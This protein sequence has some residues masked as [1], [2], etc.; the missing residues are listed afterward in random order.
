LNHPQ[1]VPYG[2]YVDIINTIGKWKVIDLKSLT[3]FCNFGISY[4][5]LAIKVMTLEKEGFVKSV[6]L[7]RKRKHLFL[8]DKGIRLTGH[9]N[10]YE[11]TDASLG[12]DILVGT[13]LR[14]LLKSESFY[15]G[16]MFHE[17]D[18]SEIYPDAVVS[19]TKGKRNYELAIEIELTQKSDPR[20]K[21]KYSRYSRSK[22]FDYCIF[23]TNKEA[24]FKAYKRFL[25]EMTKDVQT[26]VILMLA[27][28]LRPDR[29]EY[30]GEKCF[31][32]GEHK[33]FEE[34]FCD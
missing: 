26:K 6:N 13:A 2:A 7:K 14:S 20:V 1:F 32:K 10:T 17:I 19:G 24:L 21:S 33:K 31:F 22:A 9:D 27:N 5:N 29:F 3:T 15:N 30:L 18:E 4:R 12:H 11:I 25:G 23:I 16:R 8:S 28:K 34:I